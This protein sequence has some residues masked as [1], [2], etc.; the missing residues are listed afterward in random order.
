MNN[1]AKELPR[2]MTVREVA[3]LLHLSRTKVYEL[4]NLREL[5]T[6]K[7]G[8]CVRVPEAAVRELLANSGLVEVAAVSKDRRR[9][10]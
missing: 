2:L 6:V 3:E 5:R 7:I 10:R 9:V 1:T 4:I 8:R